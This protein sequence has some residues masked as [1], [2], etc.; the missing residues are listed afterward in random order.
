MGEGSKGGESFVV[1]FWT[2]FFFSLLVLTATILQEA[3]VFSID[4]R[5]K[6]G[7]GMNESWEGGGN[8]TDR[9]QSIT[10]VT[11][12]EAE[13]RIL[14]VFFTF[15]CRQIRYDAIPIYLM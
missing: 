3:T 11:Y 5:R 15:Y 13:S 6:E 14:F 9:F 12:Q 8:R 1:C 2:S 4:R 7:G 10:H